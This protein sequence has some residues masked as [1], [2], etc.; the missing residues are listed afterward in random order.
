MPELESSDLDLAVAHGAA[1]YGQV[2]RGKGVRIRGGVARSYYVGLET[3][4]PAVPG[5][6]PPIKALCVVPMG[7]EEGTETDVPGPEI[8]LIVGEPAQFRFLGSTTRRDDVPG[9]MLDRF[10]SRRAAGAR[11]AGDRAR[12]RRRRPGEPVPVRLHSRVTEVGTLELSCQ[13][14][15]DQRRWKL[16]FNVREGSD[17]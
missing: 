17:G 6:A 5:V 2:R 16:E 11:S 12:S 10:S 3:A 8:G 1:Y 7:M 14:T 15:R 13:S 4:A 9:T